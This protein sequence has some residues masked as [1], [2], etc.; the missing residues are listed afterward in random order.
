MDRRSNTVH[1]KYMKKARKTKERFW[2]VDFLRGLALIM[3]VVF[4]ILVMLHLFGVPRFRLSIYPWFPLQKATMVL[5]LL[6]VGVSLTLKRAGLALSG[7]QKRRFFL[8]YAKRGISILSWA[9]L[10]TTV[11][12]IMFGDGFV[13][14]GILHLIGL[15]MIISLPF[16]SMR[17]SS[18][19][20]GMCILVLGCFIHKVPY[21]STWQL[22]IGIIPQGFYSMDYAPVI[23]WFG[24]VLIGIFIGN[25]LYS[26]GKRIFVSFPN[27]SEKKL[28]S[29]LCCLG[30]HSLAIYLTHMPILFGLLWVLGFISL[31]PNK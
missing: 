9:L 30:R 29:W 27:Y 20:M 24:V 1:A 11:S 4:H 2:E 12:R 22:G 13:R 21:S 7:L 17:F 16:L 28:V 19:M 10:I 5:F 15:S 26:D 23:P 3:M 31:W 6:L 25:L 14:F 18:L 8:S